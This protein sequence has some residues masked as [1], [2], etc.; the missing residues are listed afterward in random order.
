MSSFGVAKN[1]AQV[2]H[3]QS[4]GKS[5]LCAGNDNSLFGKENSGSGLEP[6]VTPLQMVWTV[7]RCVTSVIIMDMLQKDAD[8][9]EN[10]L[11]RLELKLCVY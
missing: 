8:F 11:A 1:N 7:C 5:P 3:R 4:W 6:Q 9:G 10:R 2:W